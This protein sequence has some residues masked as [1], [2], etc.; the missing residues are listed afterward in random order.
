MAIFFS[1]TE[2]IESAD[3]WSIQIED[4]H[5][6]PSSISGSARSI[7]EMTAFKPKAIRRQMSGVAYATDILAAPHTMD[8]DAVTD[9]FKTNCSGGLSALRVDE[10]RLKYGP[11]T[12]ASK[13][14]KSIWILL[15]EQF[16]DRLVRILLAAAVISFA[17]ALFDSGDG[18]ESRSAAFVEPFVIILILVGNAFISIWQEDNASKSIEALKKLQPDRARVLRASTW[19]TVPSEDLIPGDICEIRVGDKVPADIRLLQVETTTLY[20]EQSQLTG[21]NSAVYKSPETLSDPDCEIQAKTNMLFATTTVASG[22]GIGIVVA[23]G[24]SSEIGLIQSAVVQASQEDDPSPLQQKLDQFSEQLSVVIGIICV[25]VWLIN[26][27]HFSIHGSFLRGSV[28][29]FKIAVALAVAAIPEGLPAVI[30]T[31][32]ALGTKRMAKRHAI[33]R[34]LQSVE[35]L[36]CTSV[37]CSDKT[38]TLTTNEMCA[39]E[40]AI[41]QSD[42]KSVRSLHSI[43][44]IDF[45]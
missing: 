18:S 20:V 27:N 38:G 7:L 35:T 16:Q 29:Y 21:E 36:G 43:S 12:L 6:M 19:R 44:L 42:S 10:G 28:Y 13:E 8:A 33:V 9:Y 39:V 24:M 14:H 25:V 34:K 32:L 17:L 3:S 22:R 37:I 23:T 26:F 40:F 2:K 41:L 1:D 4:L 45:C 5:N 31:C 15:S 30:T 11:N